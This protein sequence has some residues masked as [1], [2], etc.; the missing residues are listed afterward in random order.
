MSGLLHLSAAEVCRALPMR[1]AISAM[2]DAFAQLSRGEVTLPARMRIDAAAE[3][4][5]ALVMPCHS[6]TQKLFS[7]KMVTLFSDNLQRGLPLIQSTVIL[8]DGTT[9]KPLA[10][11]DGASLTAIRTGAVSGLATELLAREDATAVAIF[12]AGVQART[13]LEAVCCARPIRHARVY[14]RSIEAGERFAREMSEK[15]G[16]E[17]ERAASASAALEGADVV[18]TATTS[19]APVFDDR[20]IRPGVHINAVGSYRPEVVEIP[21][22]TVR[23]S[24]VVV[25]HRDSALEEAGDLLTPYRHG[26]IDESCFGTE[27]GDLMLGRTSGRTSAVEITF[28]KSVGVAIQDLCAARWTLENAQRLGIGTLLSDANPHAY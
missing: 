11:M 16:I 25:D 1:D 24:R 17:V 20:D 8:T 4:G 10:I 27:L 19:A 18:C 9:G 6:T 23:R 15:L 14:S 28:F 5:V 26:L 21:A 3:H 7:L 13:Q 12:G 2:R 22:E